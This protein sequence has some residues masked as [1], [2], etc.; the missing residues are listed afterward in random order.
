MALP[1]TEQDLQ[2][3]YKEIKL[4]LWTRTENM[5]TIQKRRLMAAKKLSASFDKGGLQIPHPV[6]LYKNIYGK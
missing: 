2:P 1:A 5:V 6:T 3:L 4:F